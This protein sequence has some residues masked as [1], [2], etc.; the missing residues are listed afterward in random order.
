[1]ITFHFHL[2][3]QYKYELFHINFTYSYLVLHGLQ[4][5]NRPRSVYQ[6]SN[7]AP[8][9]S[10]QTSIFG[11][12]FFVSKSLLGIERQKKLGKFAILTR[13]P[14]SHAWIL[15]Y[16]TWPIRDDFFNK[17]DNRI[18]NYKHIPISTLIIQLMNSTDCYLNKQ[19][20]MRDNLLS[21]AWYCYLIY[22]LLLLLFKKCC[23]SLLW[24]CK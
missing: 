13:K 4:S 16:R 8:R 15:I 18:P 7:M 1:M 24:P 5:G 21:K 17:I 10:G 3:P 6:Y 11:V 20:E 19:L 23:K 14:R 12:V 9:F 22:F 2:Q